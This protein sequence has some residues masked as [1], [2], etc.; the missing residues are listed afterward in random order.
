V[1][2]DE[3]RPDDLPGPTETREEERRRRGLGTPPT[4]L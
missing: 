2:Y 3:R 4:R 1:S